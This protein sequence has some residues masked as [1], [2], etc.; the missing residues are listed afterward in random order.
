MV[1]LISEI[2]I[3]FKA[4]YLGDLLNTVK[5]TKPALYNK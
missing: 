2:A 4:P 5:S 1:I 3:E